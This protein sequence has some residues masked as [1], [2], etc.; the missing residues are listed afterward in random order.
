MARFSAR[1]RLRVEV[2]VAALTGVLGVVT[3]VVPD[4]IEV[5]TGTDPDHG[6]GSLEVAIVIALCIVSVVLSAVAWRTRRRLQT[7]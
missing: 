5:V 1:T 4:W 2:I 3:I 6:N 7:T